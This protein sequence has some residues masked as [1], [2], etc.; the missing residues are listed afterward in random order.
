MATVKGVY[1]LIKADQKAG[2]PL[3][4]IEI[5]ILNAVENENTEKTTK[6]IDVSFVKNKNEN[7]NTRQPTQNQV[8]QEE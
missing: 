3:T 2:K 4:E 5:A 1:D 7:Q 6:E 8:K